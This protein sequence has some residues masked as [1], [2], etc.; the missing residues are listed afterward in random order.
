MDV[1]RFH[2]VNITVHPCWIRDT[3]EGSS[4]GGREASGES[5]VF[6]FLWQAHGAAHH[7]KTM[8]APVFLL[9]RKL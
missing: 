8:K 1:D 3:V 7:T 5:A 2:I 4:V 9:L 6:D